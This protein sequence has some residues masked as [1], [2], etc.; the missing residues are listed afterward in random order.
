VA[1][2]D[3]IGEPSGGGPDRS[4]RVIDA[5]T[6]LTIGRGMHV[7]SITVEAPDGS[8]VQRDVVRHPGAVAV[9]P[10]LDDGRAVLVRQWRAAVGESV[11]EIPAGLRDVPGEPVEVTARREL[12][13]EVGFR[14]TGELVPLSSFWTA[15]GL[16]DEVCHVFLATGLVSCDVSPQGAEEEAM[17][18]ELVPL[19]DV[20]AMVADGRLRDSKTIIGLLLA[21][22]HLA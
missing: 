7:D 2:D 19:D 11:L 10:V 4:F 16:L 18:I 8:V 1:G 21:R 17:T 6:L 15:V 14:A 20:P 5:H 3:P 13:E 22:E 9:V 12:A